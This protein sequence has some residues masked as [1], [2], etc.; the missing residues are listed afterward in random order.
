VGI[1]LGWNIM[2]IVTVGL[3]PSILAII[4]KL[5]ITNPLFYVKVFFGYNYN[6][7]K[8][9][10]K[11]SLAFMSFP[12]GFSILY[13]GFTIVINRYFG[14]DVL[15][16]FNTTRTMINFI[17]NMGDIVIFGVKSELSI[18]YGKGDLVRMRRIHR[19]TILYSFLLTALSCLFI[20]IFGKYIY[21]EWT[22][23]AIEFNLELALVMIFNTLLYNLWNSNSVILTSTNRHSKLSIVYLLMS[24]LSIVSAYLIGPIQSIL[25]VAAC[26]SITDISCLIYSG[27]TVRKYLMQ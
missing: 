13:Q 8:E 15:V 5:R 19:K 24:V 1:L 9:V 18:A 20:I 14:S 11:P 6:L 26:L 22:R 4:L 27:L 16:Q 7:I 21:I 12:I 2:V 17:R 25:L 23:G 10:I 3:I